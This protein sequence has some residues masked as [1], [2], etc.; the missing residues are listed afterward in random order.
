MENDDEKKVCQ[1]CVGETH[2]RGLIQQDGEVDLCSFCE[3]D[4]E[5]CISLEELAD[6]IEGAFE[7]HYYKTSTDPD[8]FESMLLRDKEIDYDWDRHGEPVLYAIQ[9][10]AS[11][12]EEVATAVLEI[13]EERHSDFD[14]AAAG[15]EC[16]FDSDSH[17]EEKSADDH[18]FAF[19]WQGIE[20]S[21][22]SES[23]FFNQGADAFLGRLFANLEGRVT[24]D[25]HPVVVVAGPS[26]A[27]RSFFR[28]RVIHRDKEFDD[29]MMRPDLLLGPPPAWAARAG[30]MNAHGISV[31]YG[32]TDKG[33][34]LA[35][36][37]P[38]VGSR[39]LVAEFQITRD[40]RLLDVAALESVF[41]EGSIFDPAY[42][43]QLSLAKFMK[44]L[45]TRITM[46]VMPDDEPTEYLITQMIAD[47]L[48]RKPA[49]ALDGILF[50][51][52]QSPGD[53]RNVVLFHHAS[54]V[55]P[56][57][58]PE[59]TNLS[60]HQYSSS[61]DGPEPDYRVWEEV[62]PPKE[63][64][65]QAKPDEDKSGFWPMLP[66]FRYDPDEDFRDITLR[67]LTDSVSAHHVESVKFK[68]DEF[69]VQRNRSVKRERK[70][71]KPPQPDAD[72]DFP[73]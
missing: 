65:K 33:V 67:V 13:L 6:H 40:V 19:E 54:R 62:P 47:Y 3:D 52:V 4:E 25:G 44:G 45:S 11:I 41:V 8:M 50:R 23:R 12:E 10:A 21:L 27:Y 24:R 36:V 46:P 66:P 58:L 32:A 72:D 38:P 42:L 37:R 16:E 5:P 70:Y 22:K 2:L 48:A 18:E 63:E 39:A 64:D 34:A 28:A 68:T 53:P 30:R 49:P 60:A 15:D 59:G 14:A 1:N 56:L 71:A 17:Y 7:R 29:A 31:F 43:Q 51:S 61:E 57:E 9:D 69:K 55:E 73:F 35:E 26:R 20:R